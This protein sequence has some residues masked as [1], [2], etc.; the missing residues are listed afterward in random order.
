MTTLFVNT[1]IQL[2]ANYVAGTPL[3]GEIN[4]ELDTLVTPTALTPLTV[5]LLIRASNGVLKIKLLDANG[6]VIEKICVPAG[7]YRFVSETGVPRAGPVNVVAND[8]LQINVLNTSAF[9]K[10]L[11][12]EG[13]AF[14]VR[15]STQNVH[16]LLCNAEQKGTLLQQI[17]DN[18]TAVT[19]TLSGLIYRAAT[20]SLS[21][22]TVFDFVDLQGGQ[23]AVQ[24]AL[25]QSN[26]VHVDLLKLR[27]VALDEL[28][29]CGKSCVDTCFTP[30]P[31]FCESR[32]CNSLINPHPNTSYFR[33]PMCGPLGLPRPHCGSC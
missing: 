8:I 14:Y 20:V 29:E 19:N 3:I 24:T 15:K 4:F 11:D 32:N 22:T 17:V 28:C 33:P 13:K 18:N 31:G 10:Y 27:V 25:D 16:N 5:N 26:S 1:L 6:C 7:Q 21:G 30:N 2:T 23:A 12:L 9:V